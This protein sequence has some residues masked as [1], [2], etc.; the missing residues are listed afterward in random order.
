MSAFETN[1]WTGIEGATL[2]AGAVGVVAQQPSLLLVAGLGVAYTAY[3]WFGVAPPPTLELT[4]E[5]SDDA[6][7]AGDRVTVTVTVRNAGDSTLS[8]LRLVDEVPPAL[9]VVEGSAR[10]GT[11]LRP[12]AS[13]TF[14]YEVEAV[15]GEHEWGP[16]TAVV[17]SPSGEE[18]RTAEF[19]AET[20][21]VLGCAPSLDATADLPLRGLTTQYTG[22]VAT[23][24]SGV[25]LEFFATREYRH[26]DPLNRID[27]KRRAK[28]GEL[29]TVEFREERAAT[30]VLLVDARTEAYVAPAEGDRNAVER[31]V[32]AATQAFT[33]LL[34][35][36]DRVGVA[37]LSPHECWLPP[38]TGAD[39]RA[40]ARELFGSHPALAPTPSEEAYFV[41][42]SIRRLRRRLPTDAQVLFFSPLADDVA[43]LTARRI[44][45]YGHLVT[46]VSP[47][48]TADDSPGRRLARI[49]RE[50][51][52][53][54]LRRSG[55][56]VLD[57]GEEPLATELARAARRWSA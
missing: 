54:A 14:S 5:L 13:A 31:S 36:G 1:R 32:D 52:I 9:E 7:D 34:D 12:G 47:D 57:W 23:D 22:R 44:D 11:A 20:A 33:S 28:T 4:R 15:R 39:H 10:L 35:S 24:V 16:L 38:G 42:V 45:A 21:T 30:V 3:A 8:D 18:E 51:R 49:E 29:G 2:L 48:P 27:W 43:T 26:G 25:G 40:R 56:R 53:D 55:I 6:P 19:E 46:V 41:A 17:R 50:N 37:A